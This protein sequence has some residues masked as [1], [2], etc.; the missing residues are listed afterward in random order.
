MVCMAIAEEL[1]RS[2]HTDSTALEYFKLS[3]RVADAERLLPFL[4]RAGEDA[5]RAKDLAAR[6]MAATD[7]D[8]A[9]LHQKAAELIDS[10]AAN[11]A[12]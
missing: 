10:L 6:T 4:G 7:G 8:L 11:R 3:Q 2:K 12:R 9:F 1:G 5:A